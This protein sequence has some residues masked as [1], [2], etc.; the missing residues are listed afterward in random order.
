MTT[1]EICCYGVDCAV[2]AQQAGA[3]PGVLPAPPPQGG[4]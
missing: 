3:H 1:L 2:T 4:P